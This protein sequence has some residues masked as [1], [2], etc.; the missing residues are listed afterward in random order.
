MAEVLSIILG[1]LS[2][3]LGGLAL[4]VAIKF[5]NIGN[6]A[7]YSE[8]Y[9]TYATVQFK[10]FMLEMYFSGTKEE[11][12]YK[13]KIFSDAVRLNR[14]II[15][16]KGESI[17]PDD[18]KKNQTFINL[19]NNQGK[20]VEFNTFIDDFLHNLLCNNNLN[21]ISQYNDL[22]D[23]EIKYIRNWYCEII[24]FEEIVKES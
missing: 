6:K 7:K 9:S 23:Y 19:L 5:T 22:K 13:N 2:V 18:F 1:A 21:V 17:T 15:N 4:W 12:E 10:L 24:G 3:M 16:V 11:L 8:I 20:V 14:M